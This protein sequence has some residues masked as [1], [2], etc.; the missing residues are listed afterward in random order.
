MHK[1]LETAHYFYKIKYNP[2]PKAILNPD[3]NPYTLT[4]TLILTYFPFRVCAMQNV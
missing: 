1:I 3:L 2:D 4:L